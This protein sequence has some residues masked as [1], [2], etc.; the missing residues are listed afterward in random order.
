MRMNTHLS[1][2]RNYF[3]LQY[4]SFELVEHIDTMIAAVYRVTQPDG[5]QYI[6]KICPKAEHYKRELF[7]LNYFANTLPVPRIINSMEPSTEQQGAILIECLPGS[8]AIIY[9]TTNEL[10]Y[11]MGSLLA[12][13]H[14][15]AT[16]GYG[17]LIYPETLN[18]DARQSFAL[19]FE[20]QF[21]ECKPHLPYDLLSK[22]WN[23][24]TEHLD[25]L[26]N[27]DGPCI[28]HRDFRPG[29]IIVYNGQVQGIIDWSG[30][31]A[32]FTQEDFSLMEHSEWSKDS[33]TKEAFLSGYASIR[34]VPDY[35]QIMPLL[36]I[37]K[38]LAVVGYF[39]KNKKEQCNNNEWYLFNLQFLET[40]YNGLSK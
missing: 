26:N 32:G 20:E 28:I 22:Y 33:S 25:L 2:Y 15:H 16:S 27:V 37:S 8:P 1:V 31:Q 21:T 11:Q 34:S 30:G 18:C 6:L 38:A 17:D 24:Y 9:Q 4:A 7:F 19:K 23:Y 14:M 5:T 12:K 39:L 3:Q 40:F 13:I 35:K 10:A 36:R 29:N